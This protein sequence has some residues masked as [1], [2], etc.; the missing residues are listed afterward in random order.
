M[1]PSLEV[2]DGDDL[3]AQ[4]LTL[5]EKLT[6]LLDDWSSRNRAN[7]SAHVA[8]AMARTLADQLSLLASDTSPS[9]R[10]VAA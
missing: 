5:V 2:A 10:S 6:S 4:A 8:A 9:L 1:D 7:A 3:H